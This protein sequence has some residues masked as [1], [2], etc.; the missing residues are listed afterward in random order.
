M[1]TDFLLAAY[2]GK[3]G[4]LKCA[5]LNVDG[6]TVNKL[7][8]LKNEIISNEYT[9]VFLQELVKQHSGNKINIK[10]KEELKD[11][12]FVSDNYIE[13]GYLL[14]KSI[15]F[16]PIKIRKPVGGNLWVT[17]IV[18]HRGSF[19]MICGS[20]YRSPS[21]RKSNFSDNPHLAN[22]TDIQK[23][24]K[25]IIKEQRCSEIMI[26]GDFNLKSKAWD[27]RY[28]KNDDLYVENLNEFMES[29]EL[30]CI[31]DP[32]KAT[33][34]RYEIIDGIPV[35]TKY[36]SL[37]LVLISSSLL[38]QC[39]DFD[40]NSNNVYDGSENGCDVINS[41]LDLEW[42]TNVS[43]HFIMSWNMNN[44]NKDNIVLK[45]TWRLNSD[46]WNEYRA[47]LVVGLNLLFEFIFNNIYDINGNDEM[48]DFIDIIT[49]K[50]A[51]QIRVSAKGTIG[52][53]KFDERSKPWMSKELKDMINLCKKYR[54]KKQNL[55]KKG[56]KR[57]LQYKTLKKQLNYYTMYPTVSF[58]ICIDNF[59]QEGDI[60]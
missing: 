50:L 37:D 5:C 13:S 46:K 59:N 31:N 55:V 45:E 10:W 30:N 18:V 28:D 9:V 43:D 56:K 35:I 58:Q 21:R 19:K 40:T 57:T 38:K 17:W 4:G 34:C 24:L 44:E 60:L 27:I 15:Q 48:H 26:A 39:T 47:S 29:F 51:K 23:E 20:I 12:E 1:D 41:E 36:N 42:I 32:V 53:K 8:K 22:I 2:G 3:K 11:Y 14:H 7:K 54:R 16:N 49:E 25:I 33:H 52:R 6:M